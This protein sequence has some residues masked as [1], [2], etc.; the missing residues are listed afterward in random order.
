MD[1]RS[2]ATFT[3]ARV[4]LPTDMSQSL[5]VDTS[6]KSTYKRPLISFIKL[7]SQQQQRGFWSKQKSNYHLSKND[8][9]INCHSQGSLGSVPEHFPTNMHHAR[10]SEDTQVLPTWKTKMK[11]LFAFKKRKRTSSPISKSILQMNQSIHESSFDGISTEMKHDNSNTPISSNT[12]MSAFQHPSSS[13]FQYQTPDTLSCVPSNQH[14]S[15]MGQPFVLQRSLSNGVF[16]SDTGLTGS[17]SSTPN[18]ASSIMSNNTNASKD[19]RSTP[20]QS[21]KQ[22]STL[23]CCNC[24]KYYLANLS[25]YSEFCGLDCK[26]A[27]YLRLG[28]KSY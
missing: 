2:S 8:R 12:T 22:C 14:V 13:S 17:T 21:N 18:S 5:K 19:T 9:L 20:Q 23:C 16:H 28:S 27:F 24:A 4:P 1:L 3:E 7:K 6:S 25:K 11:S 10:S 15:P 26:S